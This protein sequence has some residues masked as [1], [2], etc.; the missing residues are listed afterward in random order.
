MTLRLRKSDIGKIIWLEFLDHVEHATVVE[1]VQALG[2]LVDFNR[3]QVHIRS[4][5]SPEEPWDKENMTDS[6]IIRTTILDCRVCPLAL[7]ETRVLASGTSSEKQD[8]PA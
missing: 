1:P 6:A 7:F 5:G 3:R 2:F 8:T 4:W